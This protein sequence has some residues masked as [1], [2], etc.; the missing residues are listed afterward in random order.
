MSEIE[1]LQKQIDILGVA[2]VALLES[3]KARLASCSQ[4]WYLYENILRDINSALSSLEVEKI[5]YNPEEDM[6]CLKEDN[7]KLEA[8][9]RD[10]TEEECRRVD[11]LRKRPPLRDGE[12]KL[13]G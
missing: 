11:E 13:R 4:D 9:I 6:Q 7:E 8:R 12:I 10:L 1:Y 2:M 5:Q 3:Q